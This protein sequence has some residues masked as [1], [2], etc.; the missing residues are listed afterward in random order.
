MEVAMERMFVMAMAMWRGGDILLI[1]WRLSPAIKENA[2][3]ISCLSEAL[4]SASE[5]CH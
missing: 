1:F 4:S 3:P 5:L 2:A